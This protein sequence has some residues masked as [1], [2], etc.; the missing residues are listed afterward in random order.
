MAAWIHLVFQTAAVLSLIVITRRARWKALYDPEAPPSG[1]AA[2]S[3]GSAEP[4]EESGADTLNSIT[5][6]GHV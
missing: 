1:H 3:S 2:S 4:S 6:T 5:R